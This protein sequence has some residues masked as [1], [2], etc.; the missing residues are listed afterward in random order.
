[1]QKLIEPLISPHGGNLVTNFIA[2]DELSD[3]AADPRSFEIIPSSDDLINLINLATGCYS[4]L[5]GF[6]TKEDYCSVI[7]KAELPSGHDWTIP[8]LLHLA[9]SYWDAA[10]EGSTLIFKDKDAKSIGMME[11]SSLFEI[12]KPTF[13]QSVFSANSISHPGVQNIQRRHGTCAGGTVAL[14]PQFLPKLPYYRTPKDFRDWLNSTG[15]STF[16]AFSTRNICHLGHEYLHAIAL[17]LSDLVGVNVITGAQVKGSFLPDV[18]FDT[19]DYLIES[20]YPQGRVFLHNFRL[21]SFYAG[22]K[23]AFLQ[24][25][26]LQNMGFT[27]FIVGRD[28]AGIGDY[29][30]RYGSQE[31][32]SEKTDLGINILP[33][34]EPRYC[35]RCGKITTE[36][37]CA[38]GYEDVRLFSGRE[39]RRLLVQ[40]RYSELEYILRE[41]VATRVISRFEEKNRPKT[42]DLEFQQ[43]GKVFYD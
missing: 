31:I 34:S 38:H 7:S 18:I 35:K 37:S 14:C 26:M 11:V 28:H 9:P 36:R 41:E 8:I 2:E 3:K 30:P 5:S 1:M 19:Y 21:P 4:P 20:Y 22:P 17:E 24:A 16:T 42:D 29:Y 12:D 15:K 10:E 13:C 39:V 40:G 33:I 25:T 6:M 43:I 27:H 32:F 23:E